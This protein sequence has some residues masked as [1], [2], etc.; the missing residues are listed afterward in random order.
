MDNCRPCMSCQGDIMKRGKVARTPWIGKAPL[1]GWSPAPVC[2]SSWP[3][4]PG[5]LARRDLPAVPQTS[6]EA[7]LPGARPRHLSDLLR[8]KETGRDP[9]SL[10]LSVP[11]NVPE[12]PGGNGQ[13]A[14][15]AR[16]RHTARRDGP[17]ADR[18]A[19]SALL[20]DFQRDYAVSA[21]GVDDA[22]R[23]G[24]GRRRSGDGGHPGSGGPR[25]DRR[26]PRRTIP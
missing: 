20:P 15:G 4:L 12:A 14:A 2:R 13:E 7:R 3:P 22:R 19:A 11:R 16:H 6:R 8:Y 25:R 18:D 24:R 9:L 10:G 5:K 23:L 17:P 26:A 1:P 21:G